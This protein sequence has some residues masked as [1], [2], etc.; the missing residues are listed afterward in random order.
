MND[1]NKESVDDRGGLQTLAPRPLD[2]DVLRF[3]EALAIA[4]ARRDHL[5]AAQTA[6]DCS[7]GG[8]L[9]S[10]QASTNDPR[11]HLRSILD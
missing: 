11:S 8:D 1:K 5:S 7:A 9:R 2:A 3:V 4:D 10:A 6:M